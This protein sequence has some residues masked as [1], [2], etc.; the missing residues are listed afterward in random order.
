[1][2]LGDEPLNELPGT[3]SAPSRA[4]FGG[5]PPDVDLHAACVVALLALP[6][7]GPARLERLLTWCGSGER[8]WHQVTAG[9]P[10]PVVGAPGRQGSS[11]NLAARWREAA[12]G[13]DPV[14]RWKAHRSE[15]VDVLVK[16]K[17]GYPDRLVDDPEPPHVLFGRGDLGL[18][19]RPAVALVGTR[20]AT[21][22]GLVLARKWGAALASSGVAVVSGLAAG[23]DA[24]A[25][26]GTLDAGAGPG[27]TVAPIA[28]VGT[29]LDVVYPASSRAL[30]RR[31]ADTGLILSEA[32]LGT[33]PE[34]WRFPA[35]NRIIAA[36]ADV[37]VVIESHERGGSLSTAEEAAARDRM[38]LAVPGSV[39]SPAS[40]GTHRLIAEGAGIAVGVDDVLS[41]LGSRRPV[42]LPEREGRPGH[43]GSARGRASAV[44][45]DEQVVLDAL[46]WEPTVLDDLVHRTGWP[47]EVVCTVLDRLRRRNLVTQDGLWLTQRG[48]SAEP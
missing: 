30:W 43:A 3:G 19:G 15:G 37:V 44:D 2:Q 23:I 4:R 20:R 39:H 26:Q 22:Y 38:V 7:M 13:V 1:M 28:V 45:P 14:A 5:N 24:A 32:P 36:L 10:A 29:G 48:D 18:L 17:V 6:G 31:V 27:F 25:H 34:P 40:A 42:P 46:G 33:K 41:A 9:A 12:T 47:I 35:R 11:S 21:P 16:G 8:A